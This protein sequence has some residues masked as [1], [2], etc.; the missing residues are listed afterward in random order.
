LQHCNFS[1]LFLLCFLFYTIFNLYF[2]KVAM[3]LDINHSGSNFITPVIVLC[4]GESVRS[5]WYFCGGF[6]LGL[7]FW[8]GFFLTALVLLVFFVRFFIFIYVF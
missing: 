3:R 5:W 2:V 6:I 4:G 1:L 7:T 8:V